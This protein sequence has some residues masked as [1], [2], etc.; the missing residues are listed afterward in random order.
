MKTLVPI[1]AALLLSGCAFSGK[2]SADLKMNLLG[3]TIEWHSTADGDYTP[4]PPETVPVPDVLP[5][6][7]T[8]DAIEGIQ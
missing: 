3:N 5:S 6:T 7:I 4:P 8:I 2:R 1:L